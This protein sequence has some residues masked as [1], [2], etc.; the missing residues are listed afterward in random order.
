MRIEKPGPWLLAALLAPWLTMAAFATIF[1]FLYFVFG[2]VDPLI[3]GPIEM[4]MACCIVIAM[5]SAASCL[6]SSVLIVVDLVRAKFGKLPP[7][8]CLARAN[9]SSTTRGFASARLAPNGSGAVRS[10]R[11]TPVPSTLQFS[12][13]RSVMTVAAAPQ[14]TVA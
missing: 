9:S 11:S 6:V 10:W 8:S 13:Q 5:G 7:A 1:L 2:A 14:P 4:I 12:H 3:D